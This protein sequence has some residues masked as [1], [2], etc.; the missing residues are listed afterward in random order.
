MDMNK[1]GYPS[2]E[3]LGLELKER[4]AIFAKITELGEGRIFIKE[5][6]DLSP[7]QS[8]EFADLRGVDYL[9]LSK[10]YMVGV[11][12]TRD[13]RRAPKLDLLLESYCEV[14]NVKI[15]ETGDRT[16]WRIGLKK[17]EPIKGYRFYTTGEDASLTL[18]KMKIQFLSAPDWVV[19]ASVLPPQALAILDTFQDKESRREL[20]DWTKTHADAKEVLIGVNGVISE[21]MAERSPEPVA[22]NEAEI[23]E[24]YFDYAACLA[25]LNDVI[26]N[27]QSK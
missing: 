27:R 1:G 7:E 24:P 21:L 9:H 6:L 12:E 20:A 26:S 25:Y 5:E 11:V 22:Q 2:A 23:I 16:A 18:G 3:K 19:D 17:F 15:R 14:F 10:G 8:K 4:D 13:L